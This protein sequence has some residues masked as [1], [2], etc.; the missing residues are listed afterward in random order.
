[1]EI[2]FN[3]LFEADAQSALELATRWREVRSP[4]RSEGLSASHPHQTA[5]RLWSAR[6]GAPPTGVP[7]VQGLRKEGVQGSASFKTLLK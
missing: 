5:P 1:M 7:V 3:E 2:P 6:D 4:K